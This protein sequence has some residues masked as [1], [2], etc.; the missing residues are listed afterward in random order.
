MS[1]TSLKE[2]RKQ[3]NNII[4]N[5][6]GVSIKTKKTSEGLKKD[7]IEET[8]EINDTKRP[9]TASSLVAKAVDSKMRR[10]ISDAKKDFKDFVKDTQRYLSENYSID[11]SKADL[12]AIAR[13]KDIILDDLAANANVMSSDL[14]EL[15]LGNLAK[16]VPTKQLASQLAD[17]YPAYARNA[18]T[19][20]RTGLGRLFNDINTAKFQQHKFNWYTWAGPNDQATRENPCQHFVRKKFPASKL[21]ELSSIRQSLYNCRHAII[22]LTDEEAESMT[23]GSMSDYS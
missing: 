12:E 2:R 7:I 9:Y 23:E 6:D 21:S 4:S 10:V 5:I 8:L 11:L 16:G 14:K 3:S 13:K 15:L 19:I 22:P 18:E 1:V 20:M 17:L